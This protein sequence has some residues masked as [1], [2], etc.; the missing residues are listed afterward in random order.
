MAG[1]HERT[2][3][4]FREA[5]AE[6][7]GGGGFVLCSCFVRVVFVISGRTPPLCQRPSNSLIGS[8]AT[9]CT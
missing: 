6:G 7:E 4:Y 3:C 1:K 2:M 5:S 9:V 8:H